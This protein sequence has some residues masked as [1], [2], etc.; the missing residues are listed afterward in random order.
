[1]C[2]ITGA[3]S[4]YVQYTC[5]L[6]LVVIMYNVHVYWPWLLLCTMYTFTGPGSYYVQC[7]RSLA[8]VATMYNVHG[9]WPS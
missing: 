1:M 9:Y 5:L 4:Y 8:L 6:A 2:T 3:G 7:T